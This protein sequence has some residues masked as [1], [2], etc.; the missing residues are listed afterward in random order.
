MTQTSRISTYGACPAG[1][2]VWASSF[3]G[4]HSEANCTEGLLTLGAP[5]MLCHACV[6]SRFRSLAG[7]LSLQLVY[8]PNQRPLVCLPSPSLVP[9]HTLW[10]STQ[11]ISTLSLTLCSLKTPTP[12]RRS[13]PQSLN[14]LPCRHLLSLRRA[15]TL[16]ST[17][18]FNTAFS[19]MASRPSPSTMP[20]IKG[21]LPMLLGLHL[22][23]PSVSV[24]LCEQF[25]RRFYVSQ[26]FIFSWSRR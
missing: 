19:A 6:T 25:Y 4:E 10:I 20:T 15:P 5:S 14:H 23:R 16:S 1:F 7:S 2:S 9:S 22:N 11:T 24:Q 17:R 8:K 13:Y 21:M 12:P 26:Q 3:G 18:P